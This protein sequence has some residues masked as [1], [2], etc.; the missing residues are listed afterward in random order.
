MT[1]TSIL[2]RIYRQR[3]RRRLPPELLPRHLGLIL[4]GDSWWSDSSSGSGRSGSQGGRRLSEV[5]AWSARAGVPIVTVWM[6]S[7]D[8]L[9]HGAG[10]L[11]KMSQAIAET[12]RQ[13]EATRRWQINH[14]GSA[15]Q[16]PA[17]LRATLEE[18]AGR[19]AGR[20]PHT[21]NLAV[22][23]AGRQEIADAARSLAAE[24][25]RAGQTLDEFLDKLTADQ[26]SGHLYTRGQP[27]PDLIVR[28]S[29]DQRLSGFLLW[30]TAHSE[31]YFCEAS[32]PDFR[33]VDLWRAF[34]SYAQRE[35]RFGR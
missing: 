32:W 35:R 2:Y 8:E 3:L 11:E 28:T 16:L 21:V 18:A 23:Y 29:G 6:L 27:D 30:Q 34:R 20:G 13:V 24:G 25:Y 9:R 12:V 10:V 19:T 14:L 5:L 15:E 31:F 26:I 7:T 1:A 22:G 4:D 33:E 17:A